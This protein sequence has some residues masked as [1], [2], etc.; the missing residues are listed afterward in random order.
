MPP[1]YNIPSTVGR[2]WAWLC[3]SRYQFEMA[4]GNLRPLYEL[5]ENGSSST[6]CA[7]QYGGSLLVIDDLDYSVL[8]LQPSLF[9]GI[10][11]IDQRST[12]G[13]GGGGGG[14]L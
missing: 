7:C 10:A 3:T 13:G 8:L 4:N 6:R 12:G 11:G 9:S 2:K 1:E 5:A 14:G